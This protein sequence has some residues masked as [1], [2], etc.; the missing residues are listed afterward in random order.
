MICLVG[1]NN[2]PKL[3][4]KKKLVKSLSYTKIMPEKDL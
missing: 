2:L 4:P 3:N 1:K